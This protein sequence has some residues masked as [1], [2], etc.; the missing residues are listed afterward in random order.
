[1][2]RLPIVGGD[3][4][5]WGEVLNDFLG[6]VH[7]DDGLLKPGVVGTD[8][9]QANAIREDKL[10]PALRAK[11]ETASDGRELE[12]RRTATYIQWR[13][14]GDDTWVDLIALSDI[15]GPSAVFDGNADDL[16]EGG[17][18]L[19]FNPSERA[20]LAEISENATANSTD[21][22]LRNRATHTGT[23]PIGS[24]N[25]LVAALDAKAALVSPTFT[26]TPT[27]PTPETSTGDTS[28][29]TTAFT[30]AAIAEGVNASSVGEA[31]MGMSSNNLVSFSEGWPPRPDVPWPITYSGPLAERAA[32]SDMQPGDTWRT[33]D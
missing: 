5:N 28:I 4:G 23:Q 21:A 19:F 10:A 3:E 33:V 9:L 18:H 1:M 11:L 17:S 27:A 22:D 12:L 26:G 24:V 8:V 15:T 32:I 29:A 25:G 13:Y 2:A 7:T 14:V 16:D 20:K 30:H 6:Q 31:L